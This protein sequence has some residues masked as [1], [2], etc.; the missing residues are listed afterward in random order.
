MD[1]I[2]P[3]GS[4][5]TSLSPP[6]ERSFFCLDPISD[7]RWPS[8]LNLHSKASVFHTPSWLQALARTYGYQAAVFTTSPPGT[9]LTNGIVCCRVES[10]LTGRRLVSLPFSDHCE[11]LVSNEEEL[12]AL[13]GH[14]AQISK[15]RRSKYLELRPRSAFEKGRLGFVPG[16]TFYFHSL[17]LQATLEGIFH[18]F[19]KDGVQRKIH[20]AEREGLT[21]EAGRSE[22]LLKKFYGLLLLTRRRHQLPPQPLD[23]FRN[24]AQSFGEQLKIRVASKDERPIASILTLRYKHTM[25][26]KYGCSDERFHN[27]GG[28]AMLFWKAIQEAKQDRLGEFDM[29]R[30]DCDNPGLV[31]FKDRWGTTRSMLTYLRYPARLPDTAGK[32][33]LIQ[34]AKP[35]FARAPDGVLAMAGRLLYRHMG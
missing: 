6:V 33:R 26:Y 5:A 31:T 24:L 16:Q 2:K 1:A 11:P 28:M 18:N 10:W 35:I 19:H 32:S 21:Y 13:L 30:S 14:L 23:W 17:D 9:P 12:D 3:T 29:G 22:P 4:K 8:F 7:P 15:E 27:L 34:L 25:V 20:R